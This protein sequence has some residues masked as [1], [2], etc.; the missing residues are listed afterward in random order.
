MGSSRPGE[1]RTGVNLVNVKVNRATKCSLSILAS[2]AGGRRIVKDMTTSGPRSRCKWGIR[3]LN[4]DTLTIGTGKS[5]Q[6]RVV[7]RV[8]RIT[9]V[10]WTV[11]IIGVIFC[12]YS[13][14]G[15]QNNIVT[16]TK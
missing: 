6:S 4:E 15:L 5:S 16:Q 13:Q 14:M 12:N 10:Y 3:L 9:L 7:R 11:A 1:P 2:H 8:S